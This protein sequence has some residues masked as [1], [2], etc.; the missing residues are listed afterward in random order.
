MLTHTSPQSWLQTHTVFYLT[1]NSPHPLPALRALPFPSYLSWARAGNTH[2]GLAYIHVN[3]TVKNQRLLPSGLFSYT[4][5][6]EGSHQKR[7]VYAQKRWHNK[8][9]DSE[10]GLLCIHKNGIKEHKVNGA[11][12]IPD[13]DKWLFRKGAVK[14]PDVCTLLCHFIENSPTSSNEF[15]TMG[16]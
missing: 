9:T 16:E 6:T 15:T 13:R 4:D 12:A 8:Q 14:T 5:L 3:P 1:V 7:N 2:P 11:W 10:G